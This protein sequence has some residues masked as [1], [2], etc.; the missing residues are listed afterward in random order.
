MLASNGDFNGDGFDDLAIGA[1]SEDVG[2]IVDAGAVNVI[3]GTHKGLNQVGNQTWTQNSSG[4]NGVAVT[5]D[6]FGYT[7]AGGD[8]NGDGYDD[9]AIGVVGETVNGHAGAGA[10]NVLYGSKSG[11]TAKNDQLWT[12]DSSA[13]ND[14][15]DTN[16]LFGYGLAAGDFNHDGRADL[17]IGVPLETVGSKGL[18]GAVNVIYG[19]PSGLTS[20]NDQFWTQDSSGINDA[21][22]TNDNFGSALAAGDFNGDGRDD[23]AV[24]VILENVGSNVDVGATNVIYGS[25][26]GLTGSGDQFWTID[27]SQLFN[28]VDAG[29]HF[30]KALTAGDF[31][32]DGRDDLAIGAPGETYDYNGTLSGAGMVEVLYGSTAKLTANENDQFIALTLGYTP[33][34][35][36]AFGSSLSAGDFDGDGYGDLAIG[37]PQEEVNINVT[38]SGGKTDGGAA[39]VVYSS[40]SAGLGLFEPQQWKQGEGFSG[41]LAGTPSSGAQFGFA[42]AAGDFNGDGYSDLA[43]GIPH[44]A[45][46][47]TLEV[48]YGFFPH[49]ISESH[50]Y[51]YQS[52]LSSSDGSEAG[53]DFG[54]SL[55]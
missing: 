33:S 43:I 37:A 32:S 28:A 1:P 3:Y 45:N 19:S 23:L 14:S 55:A 10:V 15:A 6:H 22:E 44:E 11:L 2:S 21:A 49:L 17:A 54:A 12:Q 26:S 35:G 48:I 31:N 34:A 51:R 41:T 29:A 53:D 46:A 24:G 47:G 40:G 36:G 18:A 20:A 42:V 7:L 13:I 4:V 25:A 8:F 27:S 9:L 30:G 16:E 50:L 52:L 38:S 39:Y 5:N